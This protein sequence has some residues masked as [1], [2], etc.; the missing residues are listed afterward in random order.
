MPH[1]HRHFSPSSTPKEDIDTSTSTHEEE[2]E[3]F[4]KCGS[5]FGIDQAVCGGE[6]EG[7]MEREKKVAAA[8]HT[9]LLSAAFLSAL[10]PPFSSS[11]SSIHC[12]ETRKELLV[13]GICNIL[14]L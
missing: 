10:Q 14:L 1:T 4:Q 8:R 6:E 11:M 2:E 12:H 5:I 7:A 9:Q 3:H 13:L